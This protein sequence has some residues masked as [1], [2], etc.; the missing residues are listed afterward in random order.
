MSEADPGA[1]TFAAVGD[2]GAVVHE[3]ADHLFELNAHVLRA[4]DIT[5]GQLETTYSMR[6]ERQLGGFRWDVPYRPPLGNVPSFRR[7]GFDIM[8]FASNHALDYGI[9]AFFDTID[10]L[11]QNDIE[12][13]G[14]GKNIE[15]ARQPVVIER[16][17]VRV[18]FLA[19]NSILPPGYDATYDRPGTN[20]IRISTFYE[21][22]DWQPGTPPR[23]VTYANHEDLERLQEDIHLA[24]SKV[25]V[26]IV[27]QHSGVHLVPDVVCMYQ[28]EIAHTAVDCGADLVLQHHSH[29]L[30]GIEIYRGKPIFY[31]L[32]NFAQE[33]FRGSLLETSLVKEHHEFYKL[34]IEPEWKA[35]PFPPEARK[36]MIVKAAIK[37]KKI[38]KVGFVPCL[39]NQKVQAEVL[40]HSDPRSQ[41][42]VD[43]VVELTKNQKFD[44]AFTWD[45]DEV[46]VTGTG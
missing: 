46:V 41:T 5:L 19:Y 26:L 1:L 12:V 6:G 33:S 43:Y 31:G 40:P 32:G 8:S 29:L 39:T 2:I 44:T 45:G 25:D 16:N 10:I 38:A 24:R 13:V 30:A 17:G 9:N 22:V 20:P 15:A 34:K 23:I 21:Q 37:D 36:T 18:G 7:A 11:R 35:F 28:K 42:V 14:V 3:T 27:V 4:A